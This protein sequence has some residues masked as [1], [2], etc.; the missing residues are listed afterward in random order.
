MISFLILRKVPSRTNVLVSDTN[1][2]TFV[3]SHRHR[4]HHHHLRRRQCHIVIIIIIGS[5]RR[6]VGRII[7]CGSSGWQGPCMAW[8]GNN[9][10]GDDDHSACRWQRMMLTRL[11]RSRKTQIITCRAAPCTRPLSAQFT[12]NLH[13]HGST[14]WVNIRAQNYRPSTP[15]DVLY[16]WYFITK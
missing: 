11:D 2:C 12:G 8:R 9:N 6:P 14:R 13:C 3:F 5:V 1:N 15:N 4:H 16:S 10:D 7:P